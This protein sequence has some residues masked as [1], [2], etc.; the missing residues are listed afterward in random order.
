MPSRE[1]SLIRW[2]LYKGWSRSNSH[3]RTLSLL[4]EYS[5]ASS[6]HCK[7]DRGRRYSTTA[8]CSP[9]SANSRADLPSWSA[10]FGLALK[11]C[12]AAWT[13]T[14]SP[15]AAAA[16]YSRSTSAN[17]VSPTLKMAAMRPSDAD[18]SRCSRILRRPCGWAGDAMRNTPC[19]GSVG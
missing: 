11:S 5:N 17:E 1:L 13:A 7:L 18:S 14:R 4:I 10:Q 8:S 6:R 9:M 2:L 19:M 12:T 3:M 16:R 15:L